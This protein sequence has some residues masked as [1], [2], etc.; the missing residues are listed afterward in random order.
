[1]IFSSKLNKISS[2]KNI[3]LYAIDQ[4][5]FDMYIF[6]KNTQKKN[7]TYSNILKCTST[8]EYFNYNYLCKLENNFICVCLNDNMSI[9]KND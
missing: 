2:G 4:N 3:S 1:M 6:N 9:I 5:N 8:D 7:L